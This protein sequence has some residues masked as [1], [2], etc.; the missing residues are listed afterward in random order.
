MATQAVFGPT[1]FALQHALCDFFFHRDVGGGVDVTIA[2]G[3]NSISLGQWMARVTCRKLWGFYERDGRNW[4]ATMA[5]I[6]HDLKMLVY[7]AVGA[8]FARFAEAGFTVQGA[9]LSPAGWLRYVVSGTVKS[10]HNDTTLGNSLVNA[11]ILCEALW[12][13]AVPASVLVMG[14]DALVALYA[15][16]CLETFKKAESSLGIVPIAR[17]FHSPFDVSFISGIWLPSRTGFGFAPKPGRLV[18][19]LYWTVRPP[20]KRFRQAYLNG[21]SRGLQPVCAGLPLVRA[22][23][24]RFDDG[25][26]VRTDGKPSTYAKVGVRWHDRIVDHFAARYRVSV[27]D[28]LHC[29]AWLQTLP[30]V[31]AFLVHPVLDALMAVDLAELSARP[32]LGSLT[33]PFLSP[34]DHVCFHDAIGD[35]A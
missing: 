10:G 13:L 2:C 34:E 17:I 11:F 18:A 23:L 31:P 25:G 4:D 8:D 32:A 9:H 16:A 1:F 20:P 12:A 7:R 15:P 5:R 19:R 29:E 35:E 3:L 28:I 27:S 24:A 22:F 6:H 14:D 21:V 30:A 33:H 26:S